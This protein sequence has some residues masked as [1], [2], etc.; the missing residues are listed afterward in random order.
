MTIRE[1]ILLALPI[2]T[3]ILAKYLKETQVSTVMTNT[4]NTVPLM[5]FYVPIAAYQGEDR[6]RNPRNSWRL[7]LDLDLDWEAAQKAFGSI[8]A[9]PENKNF[10]AKVATG[11]IDFKQLNHSSYVVRRHF[12]GKIIV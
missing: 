5:C 8:F 2:A 11:L 7:K 6:C 3:F 9:C 12:D 1:P 10:S 4:Q